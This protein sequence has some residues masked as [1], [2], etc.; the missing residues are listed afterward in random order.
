VARVGDQGGGMGEQARARLDQHDQ[1]VQGDG[2]A[3]ARIVRRSVMVVVM[4]ARPMV[5]A[6]PVTM[7]LMGRMAVIMVVGVIMRMVMIMSMVVCVIVVVHGGVHGGS[8][9]K[10]TF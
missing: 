2:Q 9:T 7:A 10:G 8:A 1:R 3:E 5:V 6:M 4:A